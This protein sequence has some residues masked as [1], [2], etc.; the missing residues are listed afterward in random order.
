MRSEEELFAASV[1]FVLAGVDADDLVLV[2]GSPAFQQQLAEEFGGHDGVEFDDGVRLNARRAPDAIGHSVRMSDRAAGRGSGRLRILAQVDYG[3]DPRDVREFACFESASNLAP[4]AAPTTVLCVYDTSRL[5]PELVTTAARTHTTIVHAGQRYPSSSFVDPHEFV[6]GLGV[7]DE[8]LQAAPP[9]LSVEDAP[10]LAGLRH[11]LGEALSRAVPDRDQREDLHLAISEMA[12]NA[13]RHGGR[14][15]SARLWTSGD[16]LVCTISDG[17]RGV[18]P[19]YGYWPAHG[20]DLGRG[21]MGLWLA[22]KLCDHVDLSS[23]DNG[24]TVRL[25]VALR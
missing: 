12:A 8:P 17:G 14:P 21:G 5:A 25:A 6:R 15:V 1:M 11:R 18:D 9:V 10:T 2:G 7:P 24:T 16:R 13:F 23:D 3:P 19:L 22:R 4:F 20:L